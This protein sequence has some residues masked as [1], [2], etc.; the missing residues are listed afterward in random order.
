MLLQK[1]QTE[2]LYLTDSEASLASQWLH[3]NAPHFSAKQCVDAAIDVLQ[4]GCIV[5]YLWCPYCS[6]AH[7][8]SGQWALKADY[9]H[10]YNT[11]GQSWDQPRP[12]VQGNPLVVFGL[13]LHSNRLLF[14]RTVAAGASVQSLIIEPSWLGLVYQGQQDAANTGMGRILA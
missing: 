8:D 5:Q 1:P 7:L 2:Q 11:C 4:A 6:S 12:Q 10:V 9:T 3:T 13:H 14:S